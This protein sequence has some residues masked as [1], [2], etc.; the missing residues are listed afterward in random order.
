MVRV[1]C[2]LVAPALEM[3]GGDTFPAAFK[4]HLDHALSHAY[5][6][7]TPDVAFG[8][9]IMVPVIHHVTVRC[10]LA[11]YPRAPFPWMFRQGRQGGALARFEHLAPAFALGHRVRVEPLKLA[12]DGGVHLADREERL[13]AQCQ[14]D[15]GCGSEPPSQIPRRLPCYPSSN[16]NSVEVSRQRPSFVTVTHPFH[17]WSGCTFP[18]QSCVTTGCVALVRCIVDE[19]QIRSLPVAWTDQRVVDDFEKVSAGRSL[20][21]PD[22]LEALRA[23]IDALPDDQ[24]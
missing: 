16:A 23:Q 5:F 19:T 7:A 8:H 2:V 18:V 11:A 20:F 3:V 6:D 13:V 4:E 10:H 24:K 15:A 9:G 14:Q 21:R 1:R 22:D 12:V 17:P